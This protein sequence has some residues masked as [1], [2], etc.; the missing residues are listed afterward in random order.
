MAP[1][2]AKASFIHYSH[3]STKLSSHSH[4]ANALPGHFYL[5]QLLKDVLAASSTPGHA[6]RVISVASA[7]HRYGRI[8]LEDLNF[9]KTTYDPQAAYGQSKLANIHFANELDRR[10]QPH[11]RALSVHPGGIFTQITRFVPD[12]VDI[13]ED[14]DMAK[15]MKN[16]AQGAATQVWAATALELEAKGGLYLDEVAEAELAPVD[17]AYYLGGYSAHAF[18]PSTEKKLWDASLKLVGL[19]D[20]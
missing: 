6:S 20:V 18:D 9:D 12:L 5:F 3:Q 14:G 15:T 16:P 4:T 8:N 17:V 11:I 7:A 2:P 19:S 1:R 10:Y 13:D